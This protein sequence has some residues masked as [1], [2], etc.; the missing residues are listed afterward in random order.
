MFLNLKKNLRVWVVDDEPLNL[1]AVKKVLEKKGASVLT[2][3]HPHA[4]IKQLESETADVIVTDL[5]MPGMDGLQFLE[6]LKRTYPKIPVIFLTA[7]ATVETAVMATKWGAFHFLEK[8]F[9][10]A[11]MWDVINLSVQN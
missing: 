1:I 8:P 4:A 3:T 9:D 6:Y 7:H 11:K 10:A 2:F 5:Q